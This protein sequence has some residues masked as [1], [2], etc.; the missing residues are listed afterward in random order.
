MELVSSNVTKMSRRGNT[1]EETLISKMKEM[2]QVFLDLLQVTGGDLAPDKCVWYLII[3][4][5]KD[6]KPRLLQKHSSH[7]GI[8]ILSRST[9]TE[10]GVK[11][12]APGEGHC[13]LGILITGDGT[14]SAHKKVMT[15]KAS[16]YA[17]AIRC[18]SMWK[19][20]YGLAYNS[21]YL[22]SLGYG[23]PATT[24]TQQECYN[25]QKVVVNAILPKMKISRT[26]PRGI[27]FGTAQYGGLGLGHLAA[28]EGHSPLQY[29][30]GH[31][32]CD[33]TTG[34]LMCSMLDYTQLECS[35]TG[36]VLEHDYRRYSGVIMTENWIT[37]I[38]EN[39]HSCNSTLKITVKWK[40]QANHQNYVAVMEALTE[41]GNFSA[42]DLR[43]VNR[44][45]IY[46]LVFYI[47]D[48]STVN[49]QE[50][51]AWARKGRR[52]GGRKSTWA[53]PVQQRPTS[54]KAWKLTLEYLTPDGCVEAQ[55][56]EWL[57]KH[58]QQSEWYL[59]S[60]HN[61]LYHHSND[62]WEQ[63]STHSRACLRFATLATAC[64]RPVS[65]SHIDEAKTRQR[66][67]LGL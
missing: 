23:T 44:C 1:S 49:R 15:E 60:E 50:I 41:T 51:T 9:N 47:S 33:S 16:L 46:L 42:K 31:L 67:D 62:R 64:D 19:G 8:K 45:R 6:G 38:W 63:Q 66:G 55:L 24:L 58:H 28:Y 3:H 10:S 14:C 13:T 52:D 35:C 11:P 39:L 57:E 25:I 22:P 17:T 40:P 2:I 54:W 12:K 20:E 32:R 26:P 34:K 65:A 37:A 48:I 30:M 5:W 59:E 7:R 61:I 4:R 56:G 27:V 29:L 36:N 53:W 18:S 43:E 21:F